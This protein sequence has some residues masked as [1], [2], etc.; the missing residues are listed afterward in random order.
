MGIS[1]LLVP[2]CVHS[3]TINV[4][5]AMSVQINCYRRIISNEKQTN[6]FTKYPQ[7]G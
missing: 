4:I 5:D 3:Q 7:G 1:C 6:M 2:W